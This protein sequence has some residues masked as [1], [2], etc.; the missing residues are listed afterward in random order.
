MFLFTFVWYTL[1]NP[2]LLALISLFHYL[3]LRI[4]FFWT[5]QSFVS[6]SHLFVLFSLFIC[7]LSL[8]LSC[9]YTSSHSVSAPLFLTS[10]SLSFLRLVRH[11]IPPPPTHTLFVWFFL[12]DLKHEITIYV[13]PPCQDP[14][15]KT[16]RNRTTQ[17]L[18]SS[19]Q[20][21]WN[22]PM[23][24]RTRFPKMAPDDRRRSSSCQELYRKEQGTGTD[25]M[26]P[27]KKGI[28]WG[29]SRSL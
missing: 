14:S 23:P 20:A 13:S 21:C 8:D 9:I 3:F 5:N 24:R 2:S 16:T 1:L 22:L 17:R 4:I 28:G 7:S 12:C 11:T 10:A 18:L 26:G 19:Q 29:K 25:F 27:G 15:H 6:W